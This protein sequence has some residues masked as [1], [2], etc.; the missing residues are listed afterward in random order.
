MSLNEAFFNIKNGLEVKENLLEIKNMLKD[1]VKGIKHKDALLLLL[2]GDYSVFTEMLKSEDPKIRKNSAIVLGCLGIQ[3]NLPLIFEAYSKDQTLYNKAAYVEAVKKHDYSEYRDALKDRFTQ[4]T[5][6]TIS[7]DEK[8]HYLDEMKQLRSI[9]GNGKL[10]FKGYELPN[11]CILLTNRN[12]R[13]LTAEQLGKMP[14]RE[15][16]AGVMVKTNN[17][18]SVLPIRTYD[19]ILFIPEG[20]FADK[21]KSVHA[22]VERAA[23][24]LIEGKIAEYILARVGFAGDKDVNDTGLKVKFR[25]DLRSKNITD[26]EFSKK[27]ANE[28]EIKS[29]FRM[30]NSPSDYDIELRLVENSAGM[31]NVLVKFSILKDV[32]FSYRKETLAVSIKPYMAATLMALAAPYFKKNAAVLDPFCG[33]GTMLIEREIASSARLYYGVDI[34]GEAIEKAKINTRLAGISKKTEFITRDFM[35]FV[36]EYK[37]DEIITNMPFV[38]EGKNEKEIEG[39]YRGFFEK[40]ENLLE[41]E[42]V[43][44]LYSRN[45]E[46]VKKYGKAFDTVSEFEISKYE[47][48][49]LF[50]LK[51]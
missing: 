18:K 42:G 49:R 45:P 1:N 19:E 25:I 27:L 50:I 34:F 33:T 40:A 4:L 9:F 3:E 2:G 6:M 5:S 24:E 43:I 12:F 38:T 14:H 21:T 36:H 29:G 51:N 28:L 30:L 20:T 41:K 31:L 11:E 16:T 26:N 15:F 35:D 22:D 37:F 48:S 44:I 10:V 8:K 23:K 13:E 32:R 17:L 39:I 7:E 46:F 47:N